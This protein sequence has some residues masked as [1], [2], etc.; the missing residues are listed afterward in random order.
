MTDDILTIEEVSKYLADLAAK[1]GKLLYSSEKIL[2]LYTEL[3]ELSNKEADPFIFDYSNTFRKNMRRESLVCLLSDYNGLQ[4]ERKEQNQRI[5]DIQALI[6][7]E[8]KQI[9]V[10]TKKKR[11][12]KEGKKSGLDLCPGREL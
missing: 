9:Q 3:Q 4:S 1:E 10:E 11:E 12:E 2:G 8:R 7:F 5:Q 6:N